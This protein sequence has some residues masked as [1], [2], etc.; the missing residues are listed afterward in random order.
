MDVPPNDGRYGTVLHIIRNSFLDPHYQPS[1][2]IHSLQTVKNLKLFQLYKWVYKYLSIPYNQS[3]PLSMAVILNKT[4]ISYIKTGFSLLSGHVAILRLF[5]LWY[6]VC[7]HWTITQRRFCYLF[8]KYYFTHSVLFCRAKSDELKLGGRDVTEYDMFTCYKTVDLIK[9]IL[10]HG[11]Q[12]RQ[13]SFNFL[14][15][16]LLEVH[17]RKVEWLLH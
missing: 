11:L 3:S 9:N 10:E 16:L 13:S 7:I 17:F 12:T 1:W 5:F 14:G 6:N 8:R 2:V 15:K 4:V